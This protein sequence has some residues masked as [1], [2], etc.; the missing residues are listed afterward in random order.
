MPVIEKN[1]CCG[2][3][4]LREDMNVGVTTRLGSGITGLASETVGQSSSSHRVKL[5]LAASQK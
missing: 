5:V 4:I 3:H 1:I 2:V